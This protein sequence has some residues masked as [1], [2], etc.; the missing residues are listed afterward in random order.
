MNNEDEVIEILDDFEDIITINPINEN[1]G[2]QSNVQSD[3]SVDSEMV[4]IIPQNNFSNNLGVSSIEETKVEP[5]LYNEV[6]NLA[7]VNYSP[8]EP[9][10]EET[11]IEM[12]VSDENTKSG[13]GFVIVLFVL[14]AV[15]VIA[16]PYI[17]KLF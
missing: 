1:L 2:G 11:N 15:F 3:V 5:Q 8:I 6:K 16:L 4:S 14:L 7:D 13:L 9:E 12:N 17:S 10:R